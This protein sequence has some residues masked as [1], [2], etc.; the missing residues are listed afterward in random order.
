MTG[1]ITNP[2]S[3]IA[4]LN[5]EINIKV[6][7]IVQVHLYKLDKHRIKKDK[8]IHYFQMSR[9]WFNVALASKE[10][11]LKKARER[12]NLLQKKI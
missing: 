10:N 8:I 9:D 12:F 1:H 5:T 6:N 4:L 11:E 7:N 3:E 2:V